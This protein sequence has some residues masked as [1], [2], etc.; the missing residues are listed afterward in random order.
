MYAKLEFGVL[1][2]APKNLEVIVN[3][4]KFVITN[5]SEEQLKNAGYKKIVYETQPE[6]KE[7][8]K[9]ERFISETEDSI[10]FGWKIVSLSREEKNYLD[11]QKIKEELNIDLI[12]SALGEIVFNID[13]SKRTALQSIWKKAYQKYL[14]EHGNP[15]TKV[16]AN[17]LNLLKNDLVSDGNGY[18][19]IV[20][21]NHQA[22]NNMPPSG[23]PD[24]YKLIGLRG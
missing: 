7:Y 14:L 24:L 13:S 18:V 17:N 19:Y 5:P 22:K 8:E 3:D 11:L 23:N 10:I 1:E 2:Y 21:E 20:L 9:P 16:W 4:E 6:L 15:E 12:I